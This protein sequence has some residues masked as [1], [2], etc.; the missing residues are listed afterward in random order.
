[1]FINVH[2]YS[3]NYQSL[4]NF[5]N[6]SHKAIFSKKLFNLELYQ[7]N[8]FLNKTKIMTVLKSPHVNKTAQEHFEFNYYTK[9]FKIYSHQSLL[10]LL[11]LKSLKQCFFSDIKFKIKVVNKPKKLKIQL[12]NKVNPDNF[13][14][15]NNNLVLKEYL[16]TTSLYGDMLLN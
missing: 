10:F 1:M 2:I 13:L 7:I 15:M 5:I 3:K 9:H 4:V 6:Y 12:K 11:F 14:L 16:K 8:S